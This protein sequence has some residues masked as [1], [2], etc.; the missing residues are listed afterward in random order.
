V[1]S[2]SVHRSGEKSKDRLDAVLFKDKS[3]LDKAIAALKAADPA[4]DTFLDV[5]TAHGRLK[6]RFH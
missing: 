5:M 1:R 6:S 3:V 2:H 4:S